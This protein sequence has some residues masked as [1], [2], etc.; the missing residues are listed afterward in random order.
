MKIEQIKI[1]GIKEPVG[2]AL[3]PVYVSWK[4]TDTQ[5]KHC[6]KA[7][8]E[9]SGKEDFSEVLL[10]AEDA[11]SRGTILDFARRPRTRYYVRITVTGDNGETASGCTFFETGKMGGAF[12]GKWIAAAK[13]DTFHPEFAKCFAVQKPVACARLYISGAGL[14]EA[15]LNGEKI[16]KEFLTPYLNHYEKGLQI[17]TYPIDTLKEG[18][19]YLTI[20]CGKGWY[21]STF[22]LELK[23]NNFGDRMAAAAELHIVYTDGSEEIIETDESWQVRG[24]L[25]EDSGIYDG[26]IVNRLLYEGKENPWKPV[27]VLEH[28]EEDPGTANLAVP[29]RDRLSLPVV[30]K[31]RIPVQEVLH[32]PA[33]ETVL[34]FGQNFA[35]FVEITAQLPKGTHVKLEFG[36]IMQKGN[37]YHGEYRDAKS[38]FHF[39]SDGTAQV[40]QP[41]FT[42][43]GF[44]YVKVSGWDGEADP[45]AFCGCVLYSDLDRTGYFETGN[46]KINRLYENTIWSQRS[47]FIDIPTD[48][49][50]RSERLGWTGDAN[51]FAPTATYHM[52]T[53]AF[54]HKFFKDLR[55]EQVMVD[56]AIPNFFPNFGHAP[57]GGAIWGDVGTFVPWALYKAY[58]NKTELEEAYPMM[59][60]WVDW[61]D[62]QDAGRGQEGDPDGGRKYLWDFGFQFGDWVALDGAT[63]MSYKGGTDDGYLASLYY[64]RSAQIVSEAAEVLGYEGDAAVY[65]ALA[66]KI[67]TAIFREYFSQTGRLASNTQAAY[68]N[69]LK[70]GLYP[71]RDKII[72]GLNRR[73]E[74]DLYKIKCGFAGAPQLCTV[75]AE[76]GLF[77]LA[78]DFLFN[79]EFPG[80]IYEV[81]LGATT[82]WE[83][84]NSVSPDGTIAD[85][86][87]NSLNHYSYGSVSEFLYAYALGLRAAEPGWK[88]AIIEPHPD[89]RLKKVCGSYDSV[90]GKYECAWEVL[91]N[92]DMKVSVTVPFDAQAVLTLP[93]DPEKRVL[94][95]DA[96]SYTYTY[97]PEK[98]FRK[99][100]GWDSKL[101]DLLKDER[102]AAVLQEFSPVMFGIAHDEERGAM[103]I[104]GAAFMPFIPVDMETAGKVVEKL[105]EILA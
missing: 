11:D 21:M 33:G 90:S 48:C 54:F 39:I 18:E 58:G 67:R 15:S 71:D 65:A 104:R 3:D 94:T 96:G 4:V 41:R 31:D 84:W 17:I 91:E 95:L 16:G 99:L 19:N 92:G 76:Q 66:E 1:N 52:D 45:A 35:G 36:E 46:E 74:L 32:T 68:I 70:F 60:D 34:D 97:T 53:L 27:C 37:F 10:S 79:E 42:F 56:G 23:D 12:L 61:I 50:Q 72:E 55:D 59:K 98:D 43:F 47:N 8:V 103:T 83:R 30:I 40:V 9:V 81:N 28:P 14:F 63:P 78:Y 102:A 87:M 100:Y 6:E 86:E 7:L 69:A 26:E 57:G 5:A 24:S 44:R 25:T 29:L 51:I 85:N 49:P 62:R 38:E 75:L 20:A 77:D 89:A 22:G 64:C 105:G 82:I 93:A 88:K 101:R 2:F 73:F 13:E 80:W